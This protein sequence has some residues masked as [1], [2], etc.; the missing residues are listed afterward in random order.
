MLPKV[1]KYEVENGQMHFEN[2]LTTI[3]NTAPPPKKHKCDPFVHPNIILY[4]VLYRTIAYTSSP[5]FGRY[6]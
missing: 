1:A 3:K 6:T 2:K 5:G 4:A